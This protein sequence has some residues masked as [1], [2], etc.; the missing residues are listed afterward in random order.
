MENLKKI[1]HW[2]IEKVGKDIV[3]GAPLAAGK[4]NHL[5]NAF[6][7]E[8]LE[9]PSINLTIATALTLER[10]K[11]KSLLEKRFL[12]P[13]ADR[14]F[15]DYP[16]LDYELARTQGKLPSNIS[17][18]EFYFPPGKY[19]NNP[20]IQQNYISSNY[21]HVARDLMDR[22]VNVLVQM[23]AKSDD[24]SEKAYSL[25]CNADVTA[26]LAKLMRA[27]EKP[28]VVLGQVNGDLPFMY[29]DAIVEESFFDQVIDE[30]S[31][32]Y[33]VFGPPKMSVTEADFM[34]GLYA[35]TLV[36]DDGELQI[37]IGSLGDAVVYGL[38][39]RQKENSFYKKILTE[40]KFL[41][42]FNQVIQRLGGL[43]PFKKGLFGATEM[44]VDGF[45][46][47]YQQGILKKLVYDN[48]GIQRLLNEGRIQQKFDQ[49]EILD[50]LIEKGFVQPRI[51]E[52][53][54]NF[55][56]FWGFF[57]E[58]LSF[59]QNKIILADNTSL[60]PDLLEF[61]D[62]NK[63]IE[64]CLGD[65]L[66]NGHLVHGGFF[67]GPQ[68]FY[69]WLKEMPI[70]ERKLFAMKSVQKINQ[71]YGHE[72][73]DRLHRKNARFINTCMMTTLSGAHVSDGLENGHVVSGVGG[74]YNFVAM[75]QELPDGRSVLTMRST[76]SKKG[77][78]FS[79]IILNYGHTTVPRHMR[80][81]L[82]T[83]Y[84]IADL[85]GKTDSEIIKNLL[86]IT[87]S[88]FQ[89]ELVQ[90][91]IQSGK[92][93]SGYQI[94]SLYKDNL[95]AS[96]QKMI[97]PY[98]KQGFFNPFPF[99]TDLTELEKKVGKALKLLKSTKEKG[100]LSFLPFLVKAL[101]LSKKPQD[102]EL[103]GRMKLN[104]TSSFQEFLFQKLLIATFR[105]LKY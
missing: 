75:A 79:N 66:K 81:L 26:D 100:A 21:T 64:K 43:E 51:N 31:Q 20:Q 22:G 41:E 18:I 97:A 62:K 40:L 98:K 84:G 63:I 4:P 54:F 1:V 19:L 60:S 49:R 3:L 12:E 55:L 35:S 2:T 36:K 91:A 105:A 95:P 9:N 78:V 92:L 87:D 73:L 10:P 104:S 68:K 15:K 74:Q 57:K 7:Q 16:D 8:A 99:G 30:P 45:M 67:L 61:R 53:D 29:G 13:M 59:K 86:N 47:L 24:P 72:E 102:I 32:Y 28:V 46:E 23:I 89:D 56:V 42:K 71:L 11:G 76:R 103:L 77:K 58:G 48:I 69:R 52:K 17:V 27:G 6:Y 34:I 38:I 70:D 88:R 96:Y 44:V 83:E 85:R 101:F 82:V 65:Q 50:I 93:E 33:Q 5:M 37:G 90:Q 14:V 94:P 39:Q 80:D 25:S